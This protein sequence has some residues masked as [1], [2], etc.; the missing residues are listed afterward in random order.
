VCAG[1]AKHTP[2]MSNLT[3]VVLAAGQGTR[4]KSA[5]SKVLHPI[6]GRP[7]V[8]YSVR[9]ALDAGA[10][11]VIL[12]VSPAARAAIEE[13]VIGEFGDQVVRTAVQEVARGTG[14][15]ARVGLEAVDE[16][17]VLILCGD[18]PLLVGSQLGALVSALD[19]DP[20][21]ELSFMSCIVEDPIGYG[22]ILRSQNGAVREIRE[23][24]DLEND[25]QRAIREINAGMYAAR[26]ASLRATLGQIRPSNAQG[27]YYLTDTVAIA[28]RSGG[29]HAVLGDPSALVGVNDRAQLS[30]AED[31]LYARIAERHGKL[32]VTVRGSARIEDGVVIEPDAVI[33]SAVF[34]R[35]KTRIARGAQIDAGCVVT[36]SSIG[37]N[38]VV[39][40]YSVIVSSQVGAEAQIGPFAHLRPGSQID[41]Q[42]HVGNFV[43]TKQTRLRRGA[44][45]NHLAYLGDGDVGEKANVGAGTIFC[46]Y[47]GF[48]KHRT[49][50]GAGAFIGSDSQLVAPVTIGENAYV[51]TGT[52][53]TQDVPSEALA[54][55]RVRQE[56]KPGYASR[57]RSRL[58][59]AAQQVKAARSK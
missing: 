49:V 7:L 8:Y 3:A 4:M 34:L 52:T 51:G 21:L 10:S 33:E 48:Q 54:L 57:L 50:I 11:R 47:D 31:V 58:L 53:V 45:A 1:S 56:N 12:V 44:K 22:R 41:E 28:A 42:A 59:A 24:R 29:A 23:Q 18:T 39:K 27:E 20:K 14:D 25:E 30:R 35:G 46:N 36:D 15:A 19:A 5:L 38:A 9:A 55:S 17:R 13:Y 26:T 6:A 32:G 40:P 43:E 16:E 37:E 2:A